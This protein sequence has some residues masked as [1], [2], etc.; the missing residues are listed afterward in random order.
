MMPGD[1]MDADNIPS[2]QAGWCHE[3]TGAE[4]AVLRGKDGC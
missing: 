3:Y 4:M 1:R 2:S